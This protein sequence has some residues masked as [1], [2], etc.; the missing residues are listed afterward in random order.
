MEHVGRSEKE[1]RMEIGMRGPRRD[2]HK[3]E[4]MSRREEA[5][6]KLELKSNPESERENQ[7]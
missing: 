2:R 6:N 4:S 1:R 5:E 3:G 7:K